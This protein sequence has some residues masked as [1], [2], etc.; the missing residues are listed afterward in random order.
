MEGAIEGLRDRLQ[1]I[2]LLWKRRSLD[3]ACGSASGVV[4]V[5]K[6]AEFASKRLRKSTVKQLGGCRR[7]SLAWGRGCHTWHPVTSYYIAR[8]V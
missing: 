1:M 8:W 4:L 2:A 3:R 6:F 7:T 5:A